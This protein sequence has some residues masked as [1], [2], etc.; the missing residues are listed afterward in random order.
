ML[1]RSVLG[2]KFNG[3]VVTAVLSTRL[4]TDGK[5]KSAD[6][7]NITITIVVYPNSTT[8]PLPTRVTGSFVPPLSH[9]GLLAILSGQK[10]ILNC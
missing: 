1:K 6:H 3:Y 2:N 10:S 9:S 7:I 8:P 4:L 5:C